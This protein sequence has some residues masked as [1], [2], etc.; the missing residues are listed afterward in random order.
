MPGADSYDVQLFRNGQ[1]I[2]LPGDGIEIAF[3][4]AGAIISE[5]NHGG[6]S[7][8]FQVRAKNAHGSSDWSEFF[9]MNTTSEYRLGRQARPDNVLASGA[10][11]IDGT[12]QVGETLTADTTGIED[13]NGLDRVEFRFQ[14][15]S[16]DGSADTD[17]T[18][19]TASTYTLAA[20]DEGKTIKVRVAFTDR[21]GYA[22][23]LTSD[24]T[25]AMA[26]RPN[27]PAT[28]APVITG[29]AQVGETLTADTSGIADTDGLANVSYS[30][31]WIANDGT[32][33]TDIAGA[34][35][36]T[37]TLTGA[38]AG[39]AIKLQVTFTDDSGHTESLTSEPTPLVTTAVQIQSHSEAASFV[40]VVVSEDTSAINDEDI[41]LAITW[42]DADGCSTNYNAY[43]VGGGFNPP[44]NQIHLGSASSD[45]VSM[46]KGIARPNYYTGGFV[47][48][49]CGTDE[50]G[51]LVASVRLLSDW[52]SIQFRTYTEPPIG[53]LRVSHG[54]LTPI[55]SATKSRYD[56]PDVANAETRITI[57]APP[58]AGYAVAFYEGGN[59]HSLWGSAVGGVDRLT[60]IL[61]CSRG[62]V[63]H[64]GSLIKLTD[65]DPNTS[66]FQVDLYDGEN[67]VH[68]RGHSTTNCGPGSGY[69]LYITRAEGSIS[70]PRPNRPVI[71]KPSIGPTYVGRP[72]VGLVLTA[73]TNSVRDRDGWDPATFSYQ[74]LADDVEIASATS[75]SYTV[76]DAVLGKTLKVRVSFTDDR[77]TEGIGYQ[78]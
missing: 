23:S 4:G 5:L 9:N 1:W 54:T 59:G 24:A 53:A 16:N 12:A 38:E 27:S 70:I 47:K 20:D 43:F 74:W 34:T 71:G 63:D 40:T 10:P 44:G 33:D 76:T 69:T 21:G 68:I 15:V 73:D 61:S 2:D 7:Y 30:Y 46:T 49:Y 78:H 3:Y 25:A 65:A 6:S 56:V 19:A 64:L 62:Y 13:G 67:Y 35:D 48:L 42:R 57:T 31:Q 14:W 36:S 22:E 29:T 18:G 11:V 45:S 51:R 8:W 58:M 60:G 32:S 50:L 66:G 39:R 55:L 77:G 37:Y 52:G 17:I 26:G 72:F 41:N 75:S 28:G